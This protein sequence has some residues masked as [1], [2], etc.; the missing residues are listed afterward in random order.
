MISIGNGNGPRV[1]GARSGGLVVDTAEGEESR[2]SDDP[3]VDSNGWRSNGSGG[4]SG[5]KGAHMVTSGKSSSTIRSNRPGGSGA[6]VTDSFTIKTHGVAREKIGAVVQEGTNSWN[7][8]TTLVDGI[9]T[10][11]QKAREDMHE[12]QRELRSGDIKIQPVDF[13]EFYKMD[14]EGVILARRFFLIGGCHAA[15]DFPS[16]QPSPPTWKRRR[17]HPR[18]PWVLP[19]VC[20]SSV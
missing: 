18:R 14:R 6:V 13:D 8:V 10:T 12:T 7:F 2:N 5:G 19:R 9:A 4:M 15:T 17:C 16:R 1:G 3:Q 11:V 20:V